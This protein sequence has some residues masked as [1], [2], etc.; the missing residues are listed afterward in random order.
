MYLVILV[1]WCLWGILDVYCIFITGR[2][3][4]TCRFACVTGDCVI[5]KENSEVSFISIY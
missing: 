1:V 5:G 2:R 4:M 3:C